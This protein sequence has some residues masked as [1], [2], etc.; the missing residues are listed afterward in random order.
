MENVFQFRGGDKKKYLHN[1]E[2]D[3]G[4]KT[5]A[6]LLKFLNFDILKIFHFAIARVQS[7]KKQFSKFRKKIVLYQLYDKFR[8]MF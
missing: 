4:T 7:L 1:Y 2:N 3:L 6:K 5:V 8:I